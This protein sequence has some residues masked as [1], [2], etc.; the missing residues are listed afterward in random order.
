MKI[1]LIYLFVA[2]K[3]D[4]TAPEPE[5]YS[6]RHKRFFDSWRDIGNKEPPHDLWIVVCGEGKADL[7]DDI[8]MAGMD[9]RGGGWD[10]GAHQHA[11]KT[12]APN[13]DIC[14]CL[15]TGAFFYKPGF[16]ERVAKAFNQYGDGLYGASA[17][18]EN[19]PHIRT[20]SWAVNPKTFAKYPLTVDDRPKTFE[21]E[22][23]AN[24]ITN[25]YL[26]QA[27]PVLMLTPSGDYTKSTWRVPSN[28]FRRGDQSNQY[29]F[30]RHHL[31][32][33]QADE[34][35]KREL[36]RRSDG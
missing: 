10:I 24:S 27:K 25:W 19:T 12:I 23:G 32:Y 28:I 29:I 9:Y 21:A 18:Y 14:I 8:V 34:N 16:I 3:S 22:S 31:L 17:S 1:A 2:G 4:T 15:N 5:T 11:M 13:Y 35:E 20:T 36:A 33:D 26:S 30:D 7:P 6:E